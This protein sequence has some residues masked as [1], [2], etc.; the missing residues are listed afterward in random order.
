MPWR[1]DIPHKQQA[2]AAYPSLQEFMS[3]ALKD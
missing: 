2:R 1:S 3:F